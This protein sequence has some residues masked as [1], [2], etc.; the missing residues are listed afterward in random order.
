MQADL[1]K[2]FAAAD[3][4][5]GRGR[6]YVIGNGF[7]LH[8]RIPSSYAHFGAYVRATDSRLADTWEDLLPAPVGRRLGRDWRK[9][10]PG[11]TPINSP[12]RPRC[13]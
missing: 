12:T 2:S 7:D 1:F 9:T 11:S 8:H 6:L 13:S 10:S 3:G 5:D 4:N